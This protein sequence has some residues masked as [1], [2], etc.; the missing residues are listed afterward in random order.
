MEHLLDFALK[1]RY[2]RVVEIR[3][4]GVDFETITE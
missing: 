3:D 2:E 4:K 1:E